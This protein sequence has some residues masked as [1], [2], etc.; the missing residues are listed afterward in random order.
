MSKHSVTSRFKYWFDKQ[1]AKGTPALTLLLSV[2]TFILVLVVSAIVVALNVPAVNFSDQE[3]QTFF[4]IMW[5]TFMHAIDG[6]TI[7]GAQSI[8]YRIPMFVVTLG[9]LVVLA[10]LISIISGAFDAKVEELRKGRSKVLETNHTL[11]L[12]WNAKIFT[13]LNEICTANE[14]EK[15]P[16][17]VIMANR[18][19][20]EMQD[21]IADKVDRRNTQIIV[22]SG[23]P[24]SLV[25]L[26]ITHHHEAKSVVILAP[27]DA[28]SPDSFTIKAALAIINNPDRKEGRYHVV[29]EIHDPVN[30]EAAR[31][32]GG[33]EAHWVLGADLISRITVQACR[34]AGLSHVLQDLLDF[35]GDEF[36]LTEQP[37][38]VG[39]TFGEAQLWF[40]NSAVIGL[41]GKSH[42]SRI[43][44]SAKTTIKEGDR[45][46][47]IAKDDS[48]VRL[49]PTAGEVNKALISSVKPAALKPEKTLLLGYNDNLA[50]ILKELATYMPAGSEVKIVAETEK[51]KMPALKGI[52]TSFE[53]ADTTNRQVL[54][55]LKVENFDHIIVISYSDFFSTEIADGKTLVTLLHLRDIAKK[56]N[57][58]LNVVSEMIDDR[59]RQLAEVTAADDFIVSDKLVSLMLSQLEQNQDLYEV[60][61]E[62]LSSDGSEVHLHPAE[63]YVKLGHDVDFFTVVA[64]AQK[65]GEVAFGYRI[66]E[67]SRIRDAKYGVTL[68]PK[69]SETVKFAKGDTI[70]VMSQE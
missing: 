52:A 63:Y 16:V 49:L 33:D 21:E 2:A 47:L 58:E 42:V 13:L 6:G 5:G 23:D 45:L 59:N 67:L 10:S 4:E 40:E 25:D 32:V 54:E 11:V 37:A 17:I 15:K 56:K 36:Y 70:V 48:E 61:G 50:L 7:V 30:L 66:S 18:D 8:A 44:P 55:K 29:G 43:N 62:L 22:R 34:Q 51:P 60:F 27:D 68:N 14:S 41:D 31:L 38:L 20:V 39:K 1:M 57:I 19:K 28:E 24:M 69:K 12:G 26:E 65:R 53:K 46:I 9:G 3:E 64:A 35:A